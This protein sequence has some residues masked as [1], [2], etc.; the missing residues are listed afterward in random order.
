MFL[1]FFFSGV[2]PSDSYIMVNRDPILASFSTCF[3][4]V[5]M[6]PVLRPHIM[7]ASCRMFLSWDGPCMQLYRRSFKLHED[8]DL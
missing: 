1:F 8:C 4:R 3:P 5:L 2:S 7:A 6:P